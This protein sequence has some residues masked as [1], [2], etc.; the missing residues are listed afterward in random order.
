MTHVVP[1]QLAEALGSVQVPG[2]VQSAGTLSVQPESELLKLVLPPEPALLKLE[3]PL[4]PEMPPPPL[5]A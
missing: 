4:E 1:E 2:Q 3:L 5:P